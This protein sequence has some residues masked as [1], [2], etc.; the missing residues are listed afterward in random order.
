MRAALRA[1]LIKFRSVRSSVVL[2]CFI[3]AASPVIMPTLSVPNVAPSR[4][5][6]GIASPSLRYFDSRNVRC[7]SKWA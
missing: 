4:C 2:L 5:H 7:S 1:E 6:T 3:V